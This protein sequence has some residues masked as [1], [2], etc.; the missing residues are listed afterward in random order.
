MPVKRTAPLL[1]LQPD[2]T[3]TI[4]IARL[5]E[6]QPRLVLLLLA[7]GDLLD[8]DDNDDDDAA[9]APLLEY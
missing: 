3:S 1:A 8:V 5:L 6:Y 9:V 2:R 7:S 4:A